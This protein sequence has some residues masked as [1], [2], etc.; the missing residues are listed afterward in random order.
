[1]E[2]RFLEEQGGVNVYACQVCKDVNKK[3]SVQM[4]SSAALKKMTRDK[5]RAEGRLM[6]EK[7][8]TINPQMQGQKKQLIEWDDRNRRSKDGKY[9]LVVYRDMGFGELQVQMA[10]NGVLAPMMD[11]H[12][13]SREQYQTDQQYFSRLAESS[14]LMIHLYGD[15]RYP[16]SEQEVQQRQQ[17]T[18]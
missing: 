16:L 17:M 11:D 9:E 1:M 4:V 10:V 15:A 3:L 6:T 12:I 7:P 14:E 5:L 8:K 13:A 18:Y 2:M